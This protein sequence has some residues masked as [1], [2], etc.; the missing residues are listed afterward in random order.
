M[1]KVKNFYNSFGFIISFLF[2]C[3]IIS[4]VMGTKFL[5]K[6]LLLVFTSQ[7]VINAD[8]VTELIKKVSVTNATLNSTQKTE[9]AI[10]NGKIT[11][12]QGLR[13]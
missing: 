5:S 1:E 7:L 9:K 2:M 4:A 13:T 12:E 11:I 3:I 10:Q 6:F 8:I